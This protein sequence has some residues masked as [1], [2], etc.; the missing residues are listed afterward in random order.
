MTPLITM[1]FA[2]M[3]I[4]PALLKALTKVGYEQ[5]SAIQAEAIPP[6]LEGRD[7]IGVAQTGT[8]KTAAFAI[9][10][11]NKINLKNL[12]PQILVLTPTREL[13]IQVAEA[14]KKYASELNGFQVMPIYGGQDMSRQLR[15]LKKGVHVV[16][17]TPGRVIDHL[18]RKT[19]K[20]DQISGLVLD[21]ADEMLRMG[22][23]DDVELILSKTPEMKQVALFSA[24]MPTPIRRIADRYLKDP[25]EARITSKTQTAESITQSYWVV[26]GHHKLD[27]LT[28]ML[29]LEEFDAMLIFVRTKMATTELADKLQARG[30]A[31][32]AINGDMKQ[33]LREQTIEKLKNGRIDILVATDVAARGINVGRISHVLNYDIPHDSESYVHRI[34]RTGRAG[35]SGKAILFVA[36]K[37]RYLLK[38]IEKMTR[39]PIEQIKLPSGEQLTKKRVE[40][41]KQKVRDVIAEQDLDFY[42]EMLASF[43][44]EEEI[45]PETIATALAYLLQKDKPLQVQASKID[46]S[47]SFDNADD[48][49]GGRRNR[50]YRGGRGGGGERGGDRGRSRGPRDRNNSF[51]GK[52]G[53]GRKGRPRSK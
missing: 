41:F 19:L 46:I 44:M 36:P 53:G 52:S 6:L 13:C 17:G 12:S 16:V 25:V 40:A 26:S 45:A 20:L 10:L 42:N 39:Q 50:G 38:S 27:A 47:E 43:S 23:I 22:F 18:E 11:L 3:A 8:G 49:R 34:G 28:R 33:S 4:K 32:S 15:Q 5:P 14:F 7:L 24:T 29:E 48:R 35:K 1:K 2:D 21:E 9:P 30:F 51:R 31:A 37:E